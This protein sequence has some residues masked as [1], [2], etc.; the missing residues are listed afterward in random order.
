MGSEAKTYNDALKEELN[1]GTCAKSP[2]QADIAENLML[3]L[4]LKVTAGT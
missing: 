2:I 3:E 4:T 1:P